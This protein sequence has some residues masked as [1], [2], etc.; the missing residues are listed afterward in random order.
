MLPAR[1]ELAIWLDMP[2]RVC[3]PRLLNRS[4]RRAT[5]GQQLFVGAWQKRFEFEPA[6]LAGVT[7]QRV[8]L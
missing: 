4:V 2:L 1:A 8:Q 7:Q 3:L 6:P 5:T